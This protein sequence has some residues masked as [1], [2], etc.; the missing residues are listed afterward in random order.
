MSAPAPSAAPRDTEEPLLSADEVIE[1][2][3]GDADLRRAA[4]TCVLPAVR[5]GDAWR[6]RA[7]DLDAWI[8]R[9]RREQLP[10]CARGQ[11][12]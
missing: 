9:H 3:L 5:C 8:R 7:S 4:A 1:R 12:S 11:S 6:F 2:L 10:A